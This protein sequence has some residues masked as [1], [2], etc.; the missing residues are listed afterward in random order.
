MGGSR[1]HRVLPL[2]AG[3]CSA[4]GYLS[5]KEIIFIT[6]NIFYPFS[7]P[8]RVTDVTNRVVGCHPCMMAAYNIPRQKAIGGLVELSLKDQ[9]LTKRRRIPKPWSTDRTLFER[10]QRALEDLH[11]PARAGEKISISD[12]PAYVAVSTAAISGGRFSV[13]PRL[14][15]PS[16]NASRGF[17]PGVGGR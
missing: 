13:T 9:E 10:L 6:S 15:T 17:R 8:D 5:W 11:L 4:S 2:R 1:C 3:F 14:L 7:I 16:T 12:T